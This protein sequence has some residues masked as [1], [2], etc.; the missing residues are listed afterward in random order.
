L[1]KGRKE[2]KRKKQNKTKGQALWLMPIILSIW[3]AEV[4]RIIV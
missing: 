4:R 2:R 3:E 1:K